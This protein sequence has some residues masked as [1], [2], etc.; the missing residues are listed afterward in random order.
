M[1]VLGMDALSDTPSETVV[2]N[3]QNVWMLSHKEQKSILTS[4]CELIINKFIPF[5]FQ[6]PQMSSNDGVLNYTT[7]LLSVG[8]F[9]LNFINAVREGMGKG[10]YYAGDTCF[11]C[12]KVQVA[13]T[14][15]WKPSICSASMTT[16]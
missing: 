12:L 8:C 15:P 5:K 11:L 6:Q 7:S 16:N 9:Y 3:A 14:T 4:I 10:C 13:L 2:P 1:N